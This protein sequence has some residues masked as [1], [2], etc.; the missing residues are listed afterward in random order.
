MSIEREKLTEWV[1]NEPVQAVLATAAYARMQVA[2]YE[3]L[4][5]VAEA[6]G[7]NAIATSCEGYRI[8]HQKFAEWLDQQIPQFVSSCLTTDAERPVGARLS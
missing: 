2:S 1:R 7:E 8:E 4:K 5:T 6:A 3:I